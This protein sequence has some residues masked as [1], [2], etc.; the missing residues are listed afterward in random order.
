MGRCCRVAQG[1][2]GSCPP[3]PTRVPPPASWHRTEGD[4]SPFL[5]SSNHLSC[6]KLPGE[7]GGFV[8]ELEER[9]PEKARVPCQLLCFT[10]E[11]CR[12]GE[13]ST[14]FPLPDGLWAWLQGALLLQ[15]GRGGCGDEGQGSG[16]DSGE[17]GG[18]SVAHSGCKGNH[19]GTAVPC[20]FCW[21]RCNNSERELPSKYHIL[22]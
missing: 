13:G 17:V 11:E 12:G 6:F 15:G 14:A 1:L 3:P 21:S 19:G 4:S 9:R 7:A 18:I 22:P 10:P 20:W 8:Q 2:Q 16:C 5:S